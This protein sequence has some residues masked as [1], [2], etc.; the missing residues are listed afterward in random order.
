MAQRIDAL[1]AHA[2]VVYLGDRERLAFGWSA[3]PTDTLP[4][5]PAE[6]RESRAA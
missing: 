5:Y 6:H 3:E 1:R 4:E 2:D